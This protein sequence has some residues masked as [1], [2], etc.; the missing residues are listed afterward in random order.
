MEQGAHRKG[1]KGTPHRNVRKR[2]F[3]QYYEQ[4][5]GHE[6]SLAAAYSSSVQKDVYYAKARNY[7]SSLTA[8]LFPDNVPRAVYDKAVIGDTQL[9]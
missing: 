5:K 4:F 7:D 3:H 2:A 6:N 8:A 9:P 1:R